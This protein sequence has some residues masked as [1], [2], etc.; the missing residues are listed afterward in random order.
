MIQL[1][2]PQ[3]DCQVVSLSVPRGV[4]ADVRAFVDSA[5]LSLSAYVTALIRADLAER[6]AHALKAK[7]AS[8]PAAGKEEAFS[9]E[10]TA[11][12]AG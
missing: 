2:Q 8:S 6:R 5:G 4:H 7:N 12:S 11:A 10:P 9:A 1:P 3:R